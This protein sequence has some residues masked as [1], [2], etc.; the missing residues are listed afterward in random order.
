MD[1]DPLSPV[2]PAIPKGKSRPGEKPV[3]MIVG[4]RLE[5]APTTNP[6]ND[7]ARSRRLGVQGSI[8]LGELRRGLILWLFTMV[9]VLIK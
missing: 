5:A 3:V 6:G 8:R 2:W 9:N 7:L 4:T 1:L